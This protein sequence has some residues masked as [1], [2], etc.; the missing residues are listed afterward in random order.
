MFGLAFVIIVF[1]VYFYF[2]NN[3]SA[4]RDV[5]RWEVT[6][7][8]GLDE[9]RLQMFP[10]VCLLVNAVGRTTLSRSNRST[11]ERMKLYSVYLLSP[12]HR[13]KLKVFSSEYSSEAK[14]EL[15]RIS[16]EYNKPIVRYS[17]KLSEKTRRR[18]S[19]RS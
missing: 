12:T 17:P 2:A 4:G 14:K 11:T 19:R 10:E 7:I 15:V 1:G 5:S 8:K 9:E 13:I 18:K 6:D 16:E 3:L